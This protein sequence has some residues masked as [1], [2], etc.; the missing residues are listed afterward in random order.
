MDYKTARPQIISGDIIAFSHEGWSSWSDIESQMVK[1]WTQS[2]YSHVGIAWAIAGR[3]FVLEAVVPEIRIFPLRKL[4]PFYW[5]PMQTP[6]SKTTE[7]YAISRVGEEY[8]KWEAIKGYLGSTSLNRKWQCAEYVRTVL[9]VNG[10]MMK[11]KNTPSAI[12]RDALEM[13]KA[14]HLVQR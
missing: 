6:L 9:S 4:L 11:G 2:E 13:G 5:V 3:V 14:L 12:V 8:S 7:R 10:S 1:L